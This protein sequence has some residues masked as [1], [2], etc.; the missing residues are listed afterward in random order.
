MTTKPL[1]A[2]TF[3][4]FKSVVTEMK[5]PA[6]RAKQIWEWIFNKFV[7]S[8]ED[9]TNLSK[10]DRDKLNT[11]FPKILPNVSQTQRDKDGTTKVEIELADNSKVEVVSIPG[12][13]GL[14]FCLS[15]QVGCPVGCLF[16]RTGLGGLTRNLTKEEILAQVL[17]LVQKTGQKPSNIV[18]MG[19]GEPFLN[20]EALFASID[21]L[22]DP[23]GL[24]MGTRRITIST[25]GITEGIEQL[26]DRPGE[27]N[28]AISLHVADDETRTKLV[29]INKKYP[30][31]VLRESIARYIEVTGRRVTF[32]ITLLRS[33]NDQQNDALNLVSFCKGLICH[34]NLIQFNSF[35]GAPFKAST[36]HTAHEFRKIIKKAGIPITTRQSRGST[37]LAAC[38]QLSGKDNG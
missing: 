6:F 17:V 16:C 28:L 2:H 37:I 22:T 33:V 15:T 26:I 10:A 27:V 3:E 1:L 36:D 9:M 20:T 11:A 21:S 4:E 34:V 8:F 29:P 23:K 19:M 38:G 35:K 18:Y 7:F 31:A 13:K 25:C 32:E 14:T 30:L 24:A 5:M 12:E